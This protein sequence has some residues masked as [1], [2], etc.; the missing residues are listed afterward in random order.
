M[1]PA[2]SGEYVCHVSNGAGS[3]ETSLIVTIQGGDSSHGEHCLSHY[4]SS[5]GM[6][7]SSLQGAVLDLKELCIEVQGEREKDQRQTPK[8]QVFWISM[9]M[10]IQTR[11]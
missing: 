10:R 9:Q 6:Q 1:T 8:E 11:E 5:P 3:Q 4:G 7:A 2:D